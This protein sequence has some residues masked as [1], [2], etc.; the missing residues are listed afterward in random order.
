[1]YRLSKTF[2]FE[3]SHQL[4]YHDGKCSRLHGHSWKAKVEVRSKKIIEAGS[5]T[6]MVLDFGAM[7]ALMKP[8]LEGFLDHHHL[9]ETLETESPTSEFVAAW[10][11]KHLKPSLPILSAVTVSETCTSSCRFSTAKVE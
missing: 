4:I 2:T 11:Y 5:M 6:G 1:V 3:A 7:S 8:L 10:I 9:N